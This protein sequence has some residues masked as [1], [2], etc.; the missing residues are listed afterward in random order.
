[1][2]GILQRR[3]VRP[4]KGTK[5]E[6]SVSCSA[7][8]MEEAKTLDTQPRRTLRRR[9]SGMR[10][11][12]SGQQGRSHGVAGPQPA[13]GPYLG[14]K[15]NRRRERWPMRTQKGAPGHRP[16]TARWDTLLIEDVRDGGPSD[17][18][19]KVLQCALDPCV[20]PARVVR[21][22][23]DGETT[24]LRMDA[25][26]SGPSRPEGPLA[27]DKLTM[28]PQDRVRCHNSGDVPVVSE[29]LSDVSGV[30]GKET[31]ATTLGK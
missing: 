14:G 30:D 15:E 9:G 28:P 29:N 5:R 21:R 23:A 18:M 26:A 11:E 10:G 2:K 12:P 20:T 4:R 16:L 24:N 17:A 1:M 25:W 22:H 31:Q 27:R 13:D 6:P 7:K 8:A 3:H 19:S